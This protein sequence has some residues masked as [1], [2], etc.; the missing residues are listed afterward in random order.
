MRDYNIL[1]SI[2]GP[3]AYHIARW[4][5][6]SSYNSDGVVRALNSAFGP[7]RMHVQGPS[8][9]AAHTCTC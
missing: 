5:R 7:G 2:L 9:W 8:T 4:K 3:P 1:V 6:V